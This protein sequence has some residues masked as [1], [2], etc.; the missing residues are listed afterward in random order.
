LL[1]ELATDKTWSNEG[2]FAFLQGLRRLAEVGGDRVN[3]PPIAW[4]IT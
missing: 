1:T 4:E 2:L 3:A